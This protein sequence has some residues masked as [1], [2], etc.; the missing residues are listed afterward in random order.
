MS[1]QQSAPE[2]W[3]KA[4]TP[5]QLEKNRIAD[6]KWHE[7]EKWWQAFCAA[8][9][10]GIAS[11]NQGDSECLDYFEYSDA[12]NFE[13]S[14]DGDSDCVACSANIADAAIAEAKKRGRL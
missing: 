7:D 6:L 12:K 11:F 13:Q 4:K 3:W 2:P 5:E 8:L 1:D 10:G 9:Q 14:N